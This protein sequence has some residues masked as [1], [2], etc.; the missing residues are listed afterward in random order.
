MF[1]RLSILGFSHASEIM[2]VLSLG[3]ILAFFVSV[4]SAS[5]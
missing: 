5:G 1:T 4:G 3:G 2:I